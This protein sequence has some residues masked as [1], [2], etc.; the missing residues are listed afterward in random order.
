MAEK[1]D[2]LAFVVLLRQP[3]IIITIILVGFGGFSNTSINTTT[4]GE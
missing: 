4:K 3:L 2:R 1:E